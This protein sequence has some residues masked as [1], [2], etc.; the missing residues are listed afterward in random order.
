MTARYFTVEEANALL[1]SIE[2]LM[3][4]LLENRAR[5]VRL[6]RDIQPLLRDIRVDVGGAVP[7]ELVLVFAEIDGLLAEIQA[8]GCI[9]KDLNG[10]LLDF[11][12]ERNGRDVYLCWRYGEP[13]VA[14]YHELH[15]GFNGRR[16][17]E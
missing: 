5:A 13:T 15:T 1:P 11:L 8:F 7:S 3:G 2:P 14:H 17:L 12:S 10:G 9:I 4:Q 6:A 16:P